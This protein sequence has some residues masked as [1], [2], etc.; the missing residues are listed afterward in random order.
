MEFS[1]WFQRLAGRR[2]ASGVNEVRKVS[3]LAFGI[4]AGMLVAAGALFAS[5]PSRG[6]AQTSPVP[7]E[8]PAAT[9]VTEVLALPPLMGPSNVQRQGIPRLAQL[10]TIIPSRP[11]VDVTTYEV[12]QG[13]NL[14]AIAD[15][16]NLK[17]ET[18]LWG[19]YDVLRDN[20]QF[21]KSG[22]K[23]N[24]LP[25]DGVYYQW[26]EGDNLTTVAD[27]FGVEKD[28]ILE[29]PGNGFDL[30]VDAN[31]PGIEPGTWLIVPGGRRALKDWG[32]P[33]I[34]RSNPASARYYGSGYCGRVY[35]GAIGTGVFIWPTTSR[36][37]S[38]YDYSP[39]LHPGLDIAGA[40]GNAVY[41]SDS[42]V[43]VFSGW[44]EYGYGILVVLDHGNGWQTAYAHLSAA[45]V[46]CGQSVTRGTL[47][48]NVG[49]TG[50]STG[51]HLHFE[52]RSDIYGKANPWNFVMP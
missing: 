7:T 9:V 29:W 20:P 6:E 49:N 47:I 31:N 14:F 5:S 38:G 26:Q 4:F 46:T 33:A 10:K 48:G 44:S 18:V 36:L 50:N 12:Q 17:P 23:L 30:L 2:I 22:Q 39:S 1:R 16:F 41:A 11:R 28:A 19:N 40:E 32:P 27:F 37:I 21:L 25:T 3:L 42:G 34:T 45:G 43:V 52:M 15:K 35:E 13:D 51:P 8:E 24:I